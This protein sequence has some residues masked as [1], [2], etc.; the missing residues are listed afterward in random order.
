MF[1][2]SIVPSTTNVNCGRLRIMLVGVPVSCSILWGECTKICWG[3][4]PVIFLFGHLSGC[5]FID[6]NYVWV[7]TGGGG[8]VVRKSW[9]IRKKTQSSLVEQKVSPKFFQS[10]KQRRNNCVQGKSN[11]SL[12]LMLNI[13]KLLHVVLL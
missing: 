3:K 5:F 10:C 11:K 2:V 8:G 9:V 13:S 6:I 4:M 1:L 7:I 12:L